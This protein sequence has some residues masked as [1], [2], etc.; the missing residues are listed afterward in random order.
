MFNVEK[1]WKFGGKNFRKE[2]PKKKYF[3]FE[4][5]EKYV[6][7]KKLQSKEKKQSNVVNVDPPLLNQR[8]PP[9]NSCY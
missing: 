2:F 1:F 8:R 4:T 5:K 7:F 6:F 3:F 9:E